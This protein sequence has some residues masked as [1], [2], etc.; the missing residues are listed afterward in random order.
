MP[1]MASWAPGK[2]FAR[3]SVRASE[4]NSTSSTSELFPLPLGPVTTVNVPNGICTLMFFKL[5]CR[6]PTISRQPLGNT[7]L[8]SNSRELTAPGALTLPLFRRVDAA[9]KR[10]SFFPEP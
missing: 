2:V 4:A 10:L 6:A 3:W 9:A 8:A 5:L 7:G 1:R